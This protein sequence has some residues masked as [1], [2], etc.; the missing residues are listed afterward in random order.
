MTFVGQCPAHVAVNEGRPVILRTLFDL[1]CDVNAQEGKGGQGVLTVAAELGHSDMVELLLARGANVN[2]QVCDADV[3]RP[4]RAKKVTLGAF[5]KH[6]SATFSQYL[7]Y[8][9]MEQ[10]QISASFCNSN[11]S[12]HIPLWCSNCLGMRILATRTRAFSLSWIAFRDFFFFSH[13]QPG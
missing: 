13:A 9:L 1:G 12:K 2:S 7:L 10:D 8:P 11:F 5:L 3:R 6:C 4:Q